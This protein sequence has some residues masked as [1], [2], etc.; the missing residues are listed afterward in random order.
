MLPACK[1]SIEAKVARLERER[2][3]SCEASAAKEFG[4]GSM[5]P[6]AQA[7]CA[8]AETN[9]VIKQAQKLKSCSAR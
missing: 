2:D 7:N 3:S 9:R 8:T 4:E 1:A 5:K 6:A